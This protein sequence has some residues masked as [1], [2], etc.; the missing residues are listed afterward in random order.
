MSDIEQFGPWV[1][2]EAKARFAAFLTESASPADL[3]EARPFF[4]AYNQRLLD[5]AQAKYAVDIAEREIAGV[6]VHEVTPAGGAPDSPVLLCLHGGAFMWGEGPGAL[7]EAVPVAAVADM[8]VLA[9][10]Y[11]LAPEHVYP[12]AV[13][14]IV[15]V[16]RAVIDQVEPAKV[17][18]YGCSA[19][20]ALTA[21]AAARIARE[22]LGKPGAVGMFHGAALDFAGDS[23][24]AQDIFNPAG[25]AAAI[26]S[27]A[28]LPYFAGADLDDPLVLPGRHPE[29]LSAFPPSLLISATRDFAASPVSVLHRRLLAAGVEASFILFDGLWHAH[30]MDVDLPESVE[31]YAIVADFFRKYLG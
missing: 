24:L 20:A 7:L 26:P 22:G 27:A 31:T 14:D 6:K 11:R 17:G 16:Y 29:T 2:E 21:Q 8:R 30:H 4:A 19:G 18:I 15:A 10:D 9:I 12:A 25:G 28:T 13:D 1:S 5:K 3:A 23:V